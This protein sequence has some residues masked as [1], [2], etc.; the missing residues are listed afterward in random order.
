MDYQTN[1]RKT[2]DCRG[3]GQSRKIRRLGRLCLDD[4]DSS[5]AGCGAGSKSERA[6]GR[7]GSGGILLWTPKIFK[8]ENTA[9]HFLMDSWHMSGSNGGPSTMD[10]RISI[11]AFFELP[12]QLSSEYQAFDRAMFQ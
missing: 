7:K 12:Q 10:L 5:S 6:G 1:I 11:D 3:S 9:D 2:G 4:G 8:V